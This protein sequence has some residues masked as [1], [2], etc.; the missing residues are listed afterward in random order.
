MRNGSTVEGLE[1]TQLGDQ[2][3]GDPRHGYVNV[4]VVGMRHAHFCFFS[5]SSEIIQRTLNTEQTCP[6]KQ[7]TP[8]PQPTSSDA[9][10]PGAE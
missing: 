6:M 5:H 1:G 9:M 3:Q 4:T 10:I 7:A 8:S 2:E